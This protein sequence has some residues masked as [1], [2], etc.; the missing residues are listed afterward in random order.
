[1]KATT[2]IDHIR[3]TECFLLME[4]CT[5]K[6]TLAKA[7]ADKF[8]NNEDAIVSHLKALYQHKRYSVIRLR[9][10]QW[11]NDILFRMYREIVFAPNA[12][13]IASSNDLAALL[14]TV[15]IEKELTIL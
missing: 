15:A 1:M 5:E 6:M 4:Q 14:E 2:Y 10:E 11:Y 9:L 7:K 8:S 12:K 3:L 13:P